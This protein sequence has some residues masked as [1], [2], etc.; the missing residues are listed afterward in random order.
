[1]DLER[2]LAKRI[3]FILGE[4]SKIEECPLIDQKPYRSKDD[5]LFAYGKFELSADFSTPDQMS[6]L[7]DAAIVKPSDPSDLLSMKSLFVPALSRDCSATIRKE[8]LQ[9]LAMPDMQITASMPTLLS[10]DFDYLEEP[11]NSVLMSAKKTPL[12]AVS[13]VRPSMDIPASPSIRKS[14]P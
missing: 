10:S 3:Q 8:H 7:K 1:M 5:S 12:N 11:L 2:S 14:Q 13:I 9:C 6:S 4:K